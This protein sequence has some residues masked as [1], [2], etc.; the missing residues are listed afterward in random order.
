MTSLFP[1]EASHRSPAPLASCLRQVPPPC[2]PRPLGGG[3]SND[4]DDD[5][6]DVVADGHGDGDDDDDHHE[7]AEEA[8]PAL[9][10]SA[11]T[12]CS[13]PTLS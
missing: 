4:G 2:L 1:S 7:E 10:A 11:G 13:G 12:G 3:C 6:K 8:E 5:A 9:A